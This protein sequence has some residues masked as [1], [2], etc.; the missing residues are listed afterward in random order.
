MDITLTLNGKKISDRK[1]T[2]DEYLLNVVCRLFHGFVDE[3][4]RE[5]CEDIN[6]NERMEQVEIQVV[7]DSDG[8]QPG[9]NVR[10]S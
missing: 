6:L 10:F 7:S 1:K 8:K 5:G 2:H 3:C 4:K 9:E